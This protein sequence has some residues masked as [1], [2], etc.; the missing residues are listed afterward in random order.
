MTCW[1]HQ[2]VGQHTLKKSTLMTSK[3]PIRDKNLLVVTTPALLNTE[4]SSKAIQNCVA[5]AKPRLYTA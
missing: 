1:S 2:A 5:Q 4:V 3:T